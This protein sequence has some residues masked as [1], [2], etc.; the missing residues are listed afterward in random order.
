M[1]PVE[2]LAY[3]P[4]YDREVSARGGGG[5]STDYI[6]IVSRYNPRCSDAATHT[7][8]QLTFSIGKMGVYCEGVLSSPR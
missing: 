8:Y 6:S 5:V 1:I 2:G 3:S 7:L 4:L